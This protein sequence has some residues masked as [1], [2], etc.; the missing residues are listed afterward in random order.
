MLT[1]CMAVAFWI[2]SLYSDSDEVYIPLGAILFL[3]FILLM[4]FIIM[5]FK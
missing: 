2:V 3:D 4:T 5:V 1:I